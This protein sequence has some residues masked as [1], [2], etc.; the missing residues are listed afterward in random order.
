VIFIAKQKNT[1][2]TIQ[3]SIKLKITDYF[4]LKK[5]SA[6]TNKPMS[7]IVR[8]FILQGMTIEKSKDDIDFIRKQIR[9][10]LNSIMSGY[11]NRIIKLLV[12]IGTMTIAMC[13]F[14]SKVL[15]M[16]LSPYKE[17]FD[18]DDILSNAKKKAA[19]YLSMRDEEVEKAYKNIMGDNKNNG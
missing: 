14:T 17:K 16:L 10:E 4:S 15:Y 13:F 19:A 5:L 18:Y 1:D 9:E 6:K 11:M 8:N 2:E 3:I 7:E 12:R